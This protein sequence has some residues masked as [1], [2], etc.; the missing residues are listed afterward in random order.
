MPD[1]L[2][3]PPVVASVTDQL[4]AVLEVPVTDARNVYVWHASTDAVVGLIVIATGVGGAVIVTVAVS[5]FV[6]S[7]W[8]FARTWYVPATCGAV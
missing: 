5:L 1:V 4:T 6:A 2:T 8:L 7:A 3:L